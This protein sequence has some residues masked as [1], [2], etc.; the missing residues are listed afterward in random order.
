L[1]HSSGE[2][3]LRYRKPN[4]VCWVLFQEKFL[5][6]QPQQHAKRNLRRSR[7]HGK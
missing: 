2:L 1:F 7:F 5:D 4:N 3:R 6:K